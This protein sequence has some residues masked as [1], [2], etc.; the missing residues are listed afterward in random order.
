MGRNIIVDFD[1]TA[2]VPGCDIDDALALLFLLGCEDVRVSA[3]CTTYGNSDIATVNAATER[4]LEEFAPE[5]PL[6]R[7][8]AQ[9]DEQ[10]EPSEAARFLVQAAAAWPGELSVLATG[11]MTNLKHAA[12]L[13]PGFFGNLREVALMGGIT[14][15]LVINGRIMN[16]LNLSCDPA[17]ALA[18]LGASCPVTVATAQRCLPAFFRLGDI[19]RAFG[20]ET[21]LFELCEPWC[22]HLGERYGMDGF[23]CWDVVAAAALV[24]PGLF[25]P[26][27]MDVTLNERL[28]HAGYLEQAAEG[29]PQSRIA[30][31]RIADPTAF[32]EEVLAAW[33]RACR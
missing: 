13:D 30:V 17:A 6:Y 22:A 3:V 14:Q 21:R 9:A 15:S 12:A 27:E 4:L 5:I 18:V 11:S 25:I 19:E 16:E 29:A 28:L 31:P 1:N 24:R 7:G 26:S 32:V 33:S 20:R 23:V 10:G 2:G 8:A